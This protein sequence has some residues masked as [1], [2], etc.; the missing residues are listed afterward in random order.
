MKLEL[1]K[2]KINNK[3]HIS[4]IIITENKKE[5]ILLD[6]IF[7]KHVD[8]HGVVGSKVATRKIS[9]SYGEDYIEIKK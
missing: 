2:L 4:A 9:D 5:S 8:F 3:V 7:G 1:R 6:R